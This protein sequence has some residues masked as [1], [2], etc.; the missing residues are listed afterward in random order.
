MIVLIW[1]IS[2]ISLF[3]WGI[4]A[5]NILSKNLSGKRNL[6]KRIGSAGCPTLSAEN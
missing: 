4:I 2:L 3:S 6:W 1:M 5:S